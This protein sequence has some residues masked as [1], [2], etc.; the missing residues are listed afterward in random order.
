MCLRK[1]KLPILVVDVAHVI[2]HADGGLF[3]EEEPPDAVDDLDG[4]LEP[5]DATE[6]R[7][8]PGVVADGVVGTGDARVLGEVE[9]LDDR[10]RGLLAVLEFVKGVSACVDEERTDGPG[11]DL[12]GDLSLTVR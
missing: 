2:L 5:A 10:A 6:K 7:A 3:R 8:G 1:L 12:G 4:K 11:D 9:P